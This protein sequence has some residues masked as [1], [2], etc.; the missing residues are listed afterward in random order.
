M[1]KILS[2]IFLLVTMFVNLAVIIEQGSY[3]TH[4]QEMRKIY[5][6]NEP[7]NHYDHPP[8]DDCPKLRAIDACFQILLLFSALTLV[9]SLAA[10]LAMHGNWILDLVNMYIPFTKQ[11]YI[12]RSQR[13][14]GGC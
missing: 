9:V 6:G 10:L 13:E 5:C 12:Q 11:F 8:D 1:K 4:Y 3:G 7:E 14:G 2:A